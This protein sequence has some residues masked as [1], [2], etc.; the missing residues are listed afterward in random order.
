[1]LIQI[2]YLFFFNPEE[3][4]NKIKLGLINDY[5]NIFILDYKTF[6][7]GQG[8]GVEIFW[9]AKDGVNFLSE[10]T[11]FELIRNFGIFGAITIL[12]LLL[13]QTMLAFNSFDQKYLAISFFGFLGLCFS[14]P[15][16][17]NSNGMLIFT[18]LTANNFIAKK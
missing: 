15:N 17:F 7:F 6:L 5:L 2:I 10:L 9:P 11:Y 8:L 12:Y 18:I 3:F 13:K 16:L 14:N 1:M 4:S